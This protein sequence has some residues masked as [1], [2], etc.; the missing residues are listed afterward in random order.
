MSSLHPQPQHGSAPVLLVDARNVLRSEWPNIP[1]DEVVT[2]AQAW[3]R[4]QGA[5]AV[6]VFDGKAPGGG[7]GAEELAGGDLLVGTGPETADDW[8]T[9]E[10]ARLAAEGEELWIVT[11]DRELRARTD[12]AV[13]RT[14]GGGSFAKDLRRFRG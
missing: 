12:G 9:R 11:S 2:A 1:A 14:I 13:V 7:V 6:I 10:A 8:L 5:R 3:A 4:E